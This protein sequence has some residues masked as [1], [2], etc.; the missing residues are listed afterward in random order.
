MLN[1]NRLPLLSVCCFAFHR[2]GT[3]LGK[4][5][6]WFVSRR[7]FVGVTDVVSLT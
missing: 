6:V 4:R 7:G 2:A 3:L 1:G 5:G